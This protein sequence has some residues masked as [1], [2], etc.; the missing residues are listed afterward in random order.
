MPLI[1]GFGD[2]VAYDYS[3][4]VPPG[5]VRLSCVWLT[6]FH[7]SQIL[8]ANAGPIWSNCQAQ[9]HD[10]KPLQNYTNFFRT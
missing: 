8:P 10:N 5:N 1:N 9:M 2:P 4:L 7:N 3:I 6:F